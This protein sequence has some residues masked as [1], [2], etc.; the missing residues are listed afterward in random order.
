MR[1]IFR[2]RLGDNGLVALRQRSQIWLAMHMLGSQLSR[3][4]TGKRPYARQHLLIND[5]QRIL[6]APFAR[7]AIKQLRCCVRGRHSLHHGLRRVMEI[8]NQSK[9][10]DLDMAADH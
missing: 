4:R 6:I 10:G 7:A 9:I 8:L 5:R 2:K 3:S 1:W